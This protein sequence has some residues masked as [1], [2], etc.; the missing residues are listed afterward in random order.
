[1]TAGAGDKV[2]T[3]GL[4]CEACGYDV[5]YDPAEGMMKCPHCGS[6]VAIKDSATVI[7]EQD[8]VL[9]AAS[10]EQW[11]E[12]R[13]YRCENCG[14]TTVL[15]ENEIATR[16]P[17]CGAPR[18]VDVEDQPGIKPMGVVPFSV[19]KESALSALKGF[20]KKKIFAPRKFKKAFSP[21][22][23]SGVYIPCWLFDTNS[24]ATYSGTFGRYYTV[25]V[26]SGKN[27][28]TVRKI[29]WFT[30]SGVLRRDFN[31]YAVEASSRLDQ[32]T[33]DKIAPFATAEPRLYS[34]EYMMG[35][36]A[37]RYTEG[38]DISFQKMCAD[39]KD[40][41]RKMAINAENADVVQSLTVNVV[42][43]NVKYKY[44][45]LP[46]WTFSETYK[47]KNYG[48]VVNGE[49]GRATGKAPV[50]PIKATIAGLLGAGVVA[51]IVYLFML[52][53]GMA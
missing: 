12:G 34:P 1:M 32:R 49:T 24:H 9:T 28:R 11:Q 14:A 8:F 10:S 29:R 33:F 50:S 20:I 30:G 37:E 25:T 22:R 21:D 36:A 18:V 41:F 42:H 43:E 51:L 47:G 2:I 45:L 52:S 40:V 48:Y 4:K 3:H 16:C 46:V 5:V 44:L 38:P 39:V 53:E 26:G 17:F 15:I 6:T 35:Y 27:R 7:A 13:S 19:P 23:V 31:D